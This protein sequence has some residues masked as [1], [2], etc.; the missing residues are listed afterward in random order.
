MS[1]A[2]VKSLGFTPQIRGDGFDGSV[3]FANASYSYAVDTAPAAGQIYFVGVVEHEISEVMGRSSQLETPSQ[4]QPTALY[5]PLDLFRF[6]GQNGNRQTTSSGPSYFSVDN[7]NTD[8]NNYHFN[9]YSTGISGNDLGDW[10]PLRMLSRA[11]A[12]MRL[13]MS[14]SRTRSTDSRLPTRYSCK[15]WDGL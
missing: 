2:E 3:G 13:T 5:T 6:Q 4:S 8:L 7:G 1:S 11:R 9:N 15:R 10:A 12:P 14:R